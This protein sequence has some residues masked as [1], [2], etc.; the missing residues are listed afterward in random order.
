MRSPHPAPEVG[1]RPGSACYHPAAVISALL[2]AAVLAAAP[3]PVAPSLPPGAHRVDR[4][5]AVVDE[6]PILESDL[7]RVVALGLLAPAG[8]ESAAS[9]RRRALDELVAERLRFHEVDKF[10][11]AEVPPARVE[12]GYQQIRARFPDD[13]AF[14]ARLAEVG[15]TPAAL[16]QL[17]A[18]QLMVLTYVEERL[19]PRVFVS[20]EDIRQYYTATLVPELE[21]RHAPVPPIEEVREQ[22]RA[23]LKEKRLNDEIASWTAELRRNADVQ[24]F[25]DEPRPAPPAHV[26]P[27]V[28]RAKGAAPQR[29]AVAPTP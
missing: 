20:L 11:F 10:G 12:E 9:L 15:M 23:V 14:R 2:F 26:V 4:V 7:G 17:V 21:R 25:L 24:L 18:R 8:E 3:A 22:I 16:R 6:D 27:V 19:G 28:P 13:A 1:E 29:P 5:V